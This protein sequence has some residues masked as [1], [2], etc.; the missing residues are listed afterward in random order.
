MS[1]KH[2][3]GLVLAGALLASMLPLSSILGAPPVTQELRFGT[4]C[5]GER[6]VDG[7]E[8]WR[9]RHP[10]GLDIGA[11]GAES[12]VVGPDGERVYLGTLTHNNEN[13]TVTRNQAI[14][15]YDAA[16]GIPVWTNEWDAD[17]K[18][19]GA[20]HLALSEDGSTLYSA[21][22]VRTDDGRG[23]AVRAIDA[24]EGTD[25]W[26]TVETDGVGVVRGLVLGSQAERVFVYG[27]GGGQDWVVLAFETAT[28]QLLWKEHHDGSATGKRSQY[29]HTRDAAVSPDGNSLLVVGEVR[30]DWNDQIVGR[31]VL[32][33]TTDGTQRWQAN[34]DT[35]RT[36]YD[37]GTAAGYHPDGD[38][39]YAGGNGGQIAA[40]HASNGTEAWRVDCRGPARVP[41]ETDAL[42]VGP[43]GE[44]LYAGGMYQQS[45]TIGCGGGLAA[46]AIDAR[47]GEAIWNFGEVNHD[48][49][50]GE[51]A[52]MELTA[53]GQ[54]LYLATTANAYDVP[55]TFGSLVFERNFI[56]VA[57]DANDGQR[58]WLRE[59]ETGPHTIDFQRAMGA[60]P[61]GSFVVTGGAGE[62]VPGTAF[63]SDLT[64]GRVPPPVDAVLVAYSGANGTAYAGIE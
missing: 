26:A 53:D 63:A 47:T 5:P 13:P 32:Y 6:T 56:T 48:P 46:A 28:G 22:L 11:E 44:V 27:E 21:G 39:V 61:D 31:L 37:L 41:G 45:F 19:D 57:L 49:P 64:F 52:S 9:T 12:I 62:S 24:S 2:L 59:Y 60:A 25:R 35:T 34:L 23:V 1:L 36:K 3:W 50:G 55:G 16:T 33:N 38:L 20:V 58:A 7:C 54:R 30:T 43:E 15:A 8:M 17:G 14:L 29:D 4:P 18:R 40:Y 10:I 42:Q 51:S